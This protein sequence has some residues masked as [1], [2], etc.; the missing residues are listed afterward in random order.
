MNDRVQDL[1]NGMARHVGP[2][3]Q[4][5]KFSAADLVFFVAPLLL[6][7]WFWPAPS[8]ARALNQR[9][10][11]AALIGILIAALGGMVAGHLYH[12]ARPFVSDLSTRQL[13]GHSADNS[14]PS[15]HTWFAFAAGTAIVWW[16]RLVG[17][18]ALVVA[19]LI[20]FARVFVGV[21]WPVD[22]LAGAL[23]GLVAGSLA[24]WTVPW[25]TG[26]QRWGARFLPSLLLA[27]P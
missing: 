3:D 22:I 14:F 5:M 27:R 8:A 19:L 23:I 21:H 7:L 13:I 1:V 2:L 18:L 20:G 9:V 6:L 16:R 4:V 12:E 10:A 25:W 15:D 11:G 17:A 24:A 26:L